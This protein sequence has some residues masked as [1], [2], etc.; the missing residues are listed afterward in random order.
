[1][2]QSV[3]INLCQALTILRQGQKA[4]GFDQARA[5]VLTT[6]LRA[7]E[8]SKRDAEWVCNKIVRDKAN[9]FLTPSTSH[10]SEPQLADWLSG[11]ARGRGEKRSQMFVRYFDSDQVCLDDTVRKLVARRFKGRPRVTFDEAVAAA[12]AK[13][14]DV[15]PE[16]DPDV[17]TLE[18]YITTVISNLLGGIRKSQYL[19][20]LRDHS[21]DHAPIRDVARRPI[22]QMAELMMEA[23]AVGA[24]RRRILTKY[25]ADHDWFSFL[26]LRLRLETLKELLDFQAD[27]AC[28]VAEVLTPWLASERIL[29][30]KDLWHPTLEEC[31]ERIRHELIN[32]SPIKLTV[33]WVLRTILDPIDPTLQ[34]KDTWAQQ[35]RHST[36]IFRKLVADRFPVS[37]D[38][39]PHKLFPTIF[40][41]PG[42]QR[43]RM[44]RE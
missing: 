38:D 34:H 23:K 39:D 24:N 33:Q 30:V 29:K 26:L 28:D 8:T 37:D 41:V 2:S 11:Q 1:M 31:W 42:A 27:Q 18:P 5:I 40:C 20:R 15:L 12:V 21:L 43:E 32:N 36:K 35:K 25:T 22:P 10:M 19:E 6:A 13:V 14:W 3:E 7:P 17:E 9:I 16:C 44:H 4:V